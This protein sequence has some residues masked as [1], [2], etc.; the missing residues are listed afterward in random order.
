MPV[1]RVLPGGRENRRIVLT[2]ALGPGYHPA[3]KPFNDIFGFFTVVITLEP[4][5]S[6]TTYTARVIHK[7]EA[8]AR[9]HAEMGFHEGWGLVISQLEE[10]A[11]KVT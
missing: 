1:S 10:V 8:D 6:G 5:G 3:A 9:K 2:T 4:K 7:D 11:R